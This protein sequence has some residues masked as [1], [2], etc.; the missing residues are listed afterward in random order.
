MGTWHKTG[1]VLCT[2]NCGLEVLVEDGRMVK[3]RPDK[4]NLRSQGYVCRKGMNV[5]YH[6]YPADR[7]TRPLK[8]VDGAFQPVSWEQATEEIAEKLGTIVKTHGPRSYAYMGASSQAGHMEAGFGVS[9][10]KCLGSQNL[11]TSAGQEFSG[12]WW[13]QGRMFGKQ[14]ILTGPDDHHTPMLVA[15]GWN[16]MQSHQMPRAPKVLKDIS[17]DPDRILVCVDPRKSETAAVAN[18]HLALRP[19]TDALLLKAMIALIVEKGWENTSYIRDHVEGWETIRPLFTDFDIRSALA[20]CALSYDTVLELCRLMTTRVW[21]FHPD[22]GIYMG[23]HSTLNSYLLNIL[24]AICG[25]FG[26]RGGNVIPGMF[27]PL[28]SHGD[29]RNPKVWK[30]AV[31]G[32]PPAA[33]GSFPATAL[34]E[35]I[36]TDHPDRIRAAI[37]SVANPLRAWPDTQAL[38]KAFRHLDLL[39]VHDFVM[40]ETAREA[41]YVL[42][43]RS[44]YESWD[45][46]FFP[47]SFPEVY[48]QLRRPVVDPPGICLEAS[49]I[50]TLIADK[51]GLIPEIPEGVMAAAKKDRMT[52]A[53]ELMGWLGNHPEH[54]GKI[55]FILGKT[56]GREWDSAAL[57]GLWG[58]TM[59]APKS[60]RENAIRLGFAKGFD[61]GD[62]IFQAVLDHPEGLWVGKVDETK[63]LEGVKTPSGKIEMVI[64]EFMAFLGAM[65]AESE[66]ADLEPSGAF[67]MI[68]NAG[69]HRMTVM[70][71]QMRNPEW[72]AGKRGCTIAIHPKE[73]AKLGLQDQDPAKVVTEAGSAV[74]ELEVTEAVREGM[75]LI[76]HGFGLIYDGKK[77]GINVNDLT[78]NTHRDPIGTP[79]HRF[80][81]CRLERA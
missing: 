12:T 5:L 81:P 31:T 61:L 78:K 6:Q 42:P 7:L 2:Q 53:A 18:I 24:G 45:T 67:P 37:V 29:E 21:A 69:R 27:A 33:A 10:M 38:T 44:F 55:L 20:V 72:I 74:G 54:M 76:P 25:V 14:Y 3:V 75:V 28:G 64:P 63:N 8:K 22:L 19:G 73:A 1:C 15:W 43:C 68:L 57:A 39:V 80:V 35:E 62:R 79:L 4:E 52:F 77:T 65:D 16:G 47:Y 59:T 60:F 36:L 70:N 66:K 13:V 23:R 49:Q 32:M 9:L 48:L 46:A 50:F 11:Y 51:M 58:M 40:S 56:L 71:T 17:R 30:T 41:D 34:P 26:V